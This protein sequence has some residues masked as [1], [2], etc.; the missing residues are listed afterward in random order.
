[1]KWNSRLSWVKRTGS[2]SASAVAMFRLTWNAAWT[3]SGVGFGKS[4]SIGR[5]RTGKM[6]VPIRGRGGFALKGAG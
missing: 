3:V 5:R 4:Y 6:A 2:K 1:M